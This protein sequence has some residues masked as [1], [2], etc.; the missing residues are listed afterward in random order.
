MKRGVLLAAAAA[1][2]IAGC[3]GQQGK[4]EVRA[5]PTPLAA[6]PK[7]V[8][9]RIAEARGHFALG[10]VALALEGYRKALREDPG[11]IDAMTGIAASYDRMGRFDLSRRHYE[12]ALAA[13]PGDPAVLA[14]F[15]ASL[16]LQ[17]RASE[18]RLVLQEIRDRAAAA[19]PVVSPTAPKALAPVV[20]AAR[21]AQPV[22]TPPRPAAVAAPA[23]A[24]AP[25]QA[26][27]VPPRASV[28]AP[29]ASAVAPQPPAPKVAQAV[30]PKPVSSAVGRSVTIVLPPARPEA[31]ATLVKPVPSEVP[32]RSSAA[33]VARAEVPARPATPVSAP[34]APIAPPKAAAAAASPP[35]AP[36][37]R[38]EPS[39]RPLPPKAVVGSALKT[40]KATKGSPNGRVSPRLER[41][42]LREVALITA[43]GPQWR[44]LTVV[45]TERSA[46]VRFVPVRPAPGRVA[47]IRLL[48]AAR[49]DKL[50]ARTRLYLVGRGWRSISIGDA[51][52]IR[53]RSV[54]LYPAGRR[55][56][57][58]RLSAQFG[59]A[60]A[61]RASA[62]Q[63]TIL[64]GRDA[65]RI[66]V[67]R[68]KG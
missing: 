39:A 15:A 30:R 16:T 24:A 35:A 57:A 50:A 44:P 32:L 59:F 38:L 47:G 10:N 43:S 8:P 41:T 20:A 31:A 53:T 26:V 22:A 67:L 33:V 29:P 27:A 66:S 21:P 55:R 42:S 49:V 3:G 28:V 13:A 1:T 37:P 68:A 18:A 17:G 6:G 58:E 52:A 45:R 64:L 25:A 46:T 5:L 34:P 23:V 40:A 54:I 62:R 36:Q 48:N 12:T 2:A 51:P 65:A 7:P 4:L 56:S 60:I 11:S 14:A 61:Q 63:L 9:F 19:T